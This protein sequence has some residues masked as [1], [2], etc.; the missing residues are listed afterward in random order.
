MSVDA[1]R[2]QAGYFRPKKG[3]PALAGSSRT[4]AAAYKGGPRFR[5]CGEAVELRF[6]ETAYLARIIQR[7]RCITGYI[8][9]RRGRS[10]PAAPFGGTWSAAGLDAFR[11]R[12]GINA[13]RPDGNPCY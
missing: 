3:R 2:P 4:T 1:D 5:Q 6:F 9:E 10:S 8:A 13:P 7:L 12:T 11:F